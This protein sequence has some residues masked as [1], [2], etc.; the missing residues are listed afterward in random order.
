MTKPGNSK[1]GWSK[2]RERSISDGAIV[3]F[4][5]ELGGKLQLRFELRARKLSQDPPDDKQTIPAKQSGLAI[6]GW[7]GGYSPSLDGKPIELETREISLS[8][9]VHPDGNR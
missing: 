4:A 9:A 7:A 5:F 2:V 1:P 3:D 8:F 6:E